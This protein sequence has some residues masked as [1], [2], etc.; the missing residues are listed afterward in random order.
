MIQDAL[1]FAHAAG[2]MLSR[3]D[4][5]V[6]KMH[7]CARDPEETR[8][9]WRVLRVYS[10]SKICFSFQDLRSSHGLNDEMKRLAKSNVQQVQ[11]QCQYA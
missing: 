10:Q 7:A 11:Y 1:S 4:T 2:S 8:R 5:R 6:G 3:R 9:A